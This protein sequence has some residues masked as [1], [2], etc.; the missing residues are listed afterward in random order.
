MQEGF[1]LVTVHFH[2]TDSTFHLTQERFF[3]N[4]SRNVDDQSS[5][6][7]PLNYGTAS[8]VDFEDTSTSDFFPD[9][10]NEFNIVDTNYDGEEWF[11][12]NKQQVG[13]Y[14][15][16]YDEKNWN[17]LTKA[18]NSDEFEK[19][20]VSNRVQLIDDSFSLAFAGYI[21]LQIP[22]EVMLYLRHETN[23]FAWD[24]ASDFIYKLFD[25][26]GPRNEALNVSF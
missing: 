17:A 16:N 9:G 20:H 5:W 26:F 8:N 1:P 6:Y 13:Y 23:Y 12:F 10:T 25:V 21:D 2:S 22:Y 4:K 3:N 7:I 15:V 24:V 18:L 11:I 14:R 19:I